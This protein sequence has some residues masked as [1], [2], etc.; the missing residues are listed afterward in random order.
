MYNVFVDK[1]YFGFLLI[2]LDGVSCFTYFISLHW[3]ELNFHTANFNLK[4][5]VIFTLN[6]FKKTKNKKLFSCKWKYVLQKGSVYIESDKAYF[7]IKRNGDNE[8]N[9]QFVV[10]CLFVMCYKVLLLSSVDCFK[11]KPFSILSIV[12]FIGIVWNTDI[13]R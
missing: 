6:I 12:Q 8:M 5:L 2:F 10:L 13:H 1:I 9:S 7:K 11:I 4:I 3:I